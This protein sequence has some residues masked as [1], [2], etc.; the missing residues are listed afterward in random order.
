M[1]L[2][3][4]PIT[5]SVLAV[6]VILSRIIRFIQKEQGQTLFKLL[7]TVGVWGTVSYISLFPNHIR[8]VSRQLGFGEN[9][10]TFIFFGF[11]VVFVILFRLLSLLE[12]NERMLTEIIR[13]Q[14]L[15]DL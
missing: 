5:F 8:F 9:L 4:L 2:T 10:N 6:L 3:V 12:K 7:M 1:N 15:K 14:A 11:V 13:K